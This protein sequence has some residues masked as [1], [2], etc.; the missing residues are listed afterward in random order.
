MEE[1][2]RNMSLAGPPRMLNPPR[3]VMMDPAYQQPPPVRGPSV[4]VGGYS[5]AVGGPAPIP[6]RPVLRPPLSASVAAG[7]RNAPPGAVPVNYPASSVTPTFY[8]AA[9]DDDDDDDGY[10]VDTHSLMSTVSSAL[11]FISVY[12]GPQHWLEVRNVISE[13]IVQKT[14]LNRSIATDR[15]WKRKQASRSSPKRLPNLQG[16][17]K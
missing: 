2:M 5:A 10:S 7:F 14:E 17:A 1:G 13:A 12:S 16:V 11:L 3:P 6:V 8:S 15:H 4:P 9:Q